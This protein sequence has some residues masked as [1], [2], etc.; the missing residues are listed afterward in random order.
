MPALS[1]LT[2]ILLIACGGA[3][4]Q[5]AQPEVEE[6][7]TIDYKEEIGAAMTLYKKSYEAREL[8]GLQ[9]LYESG[10]DLALV[11]QGRLYSGVS[12][13]QDFLGKRI[14]SAS[15]V[16]ITMADIRVRGL[17]KN[18]ASASCDFEITVGDDAVSV[19]EKGLLTLVYRKEGDKW[20]IASEHFSRPASR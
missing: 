12:Q 20:L 18:S 10:L 3:P 19:T 15:Q 7:L 11:Y 14:G 2:V 16:R 4:I 17:D 13:V 8:Q 1:L 9:A 6:S 5:P